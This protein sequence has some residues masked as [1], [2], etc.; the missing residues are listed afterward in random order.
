[1]TGKA[2]Y[3]AEVPA[4]GVAYAV[5]VGSAVAKGKI[6]GIDS[7]R[8]AR[9]PGVLAILSHLKPPLVPK[10]GKSSEGGT[11]RVLQVLQNDEVLYSGQP[12]AVVVADTFER[13]REG[14]RLLQITYDAAT[15]TVDFAHGAEANVFVPGKKEEA[16]IG[17]GDALGAFAAA[18]VKL[19]Q[20]YATPVETHNPMEMHATTAVW[21][22]DKKLTLYDSTQG[23]FEEK[24]KVAATLGLDPADVRVVSPYVGGGFGSKGSVWSHVVL[25]A[26]AR[27]RGEATGEAG[28]RASADVRLRRASSGH[29]AAAAARSDQGGR[30]PGDPA[31][32]GEL[33]VVVRSL[34]GEGDGA[35]A[36]DLRVSKRRDEPAAHP[37]RRGDAAVHA[38]TR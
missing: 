15:P 30:P 19:D 18:E 13:A 1:M 5:I 2:Q 38:R 34:P 10:P 20:V 29:A 28:G 16:D 22:S 11:D 23:I 27:A 25:A 31:H 33:D 14:A 24:R 37:S 7:G 35:H 12:V 26:V 36:R 6:T 17:R 3:S 32:G 8:A 4:D 9:V 21:L